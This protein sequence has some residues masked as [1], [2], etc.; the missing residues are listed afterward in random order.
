MGHSAKEASFS[1]SGS[2]PRLVLIVA[3]FLLAAGRATAQSPSSL[4]S[5]PPP[6]SNNG[7]TVSRPTG[8]SKSPDLK[9]AKAESLLEKGQLND[10]E[11]IVRQDLK[12]APDSAAAHFM[13][14]YILY[15]QIQAQAKQVD[16]NPN[17]IYAAPKKSLVELSEKNAKESL[18]EFTAGARYRTPSAF[19]LKIVAIDYILLGDS[20]D[21]DK[22]LTR[23]LQLN[24]TDSDGWYQLGRTK[25]NEN[26]FTEAIDA[27]KKCLAIDATN[28]KAEEN[29]GLSYAGLGDDLHAAK[30]YQTAIDW[31]TTSVTKDVETYLAFG[32]L[33]LDE[34]R[35]KDAIPLLI[36]ATE[37]A[38]S[39]FQGHELLGKAYLQTQELLKAQTELEEAVNLSPDTARLHYILGQVYR[40]EGLMAK[41]KAEFDRCAALQG[42]GPSDPREM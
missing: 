3:A 38:P 27:F 41:A 9:L 29:L 28:I 5:I 1:R 10:A 31:Q 39:V 11:I 32:T 20:I 34:N 37:I 21:A 15:R 4:P 40:K 18:A 7:E 17:A 14:G 33:L 22:W 2:F 6:A 24:P 12:I 35:P 23:S 25:Y 8:L 30:A 36:Q 13:L 42:A 26:R 19:D 16:P